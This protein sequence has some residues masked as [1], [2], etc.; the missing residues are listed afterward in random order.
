MHT[1][2]WW[3][4]GLLVLHIGAIRAQDCDNDNTLIDDVNLPDGTIT[5][6]CPGTVQTPCMLG[7]EYVIVNVVAGN[8]YTFSTCG[9]SWD[10]QLTLWSNTNTWLGMNDNYGPCGQ[11]SQ[12]SWVATYTGPVWVLL[13]ESYCG[14]FSSEPTPCGSVAV[15]CTPPL[16]ND[17]CANATPVGNGLTSFSTIG[18]TG[19][20]ISSC[21][22]NDSRDVWF[23]YEA[24]CLGTVTVSTCGMANFNTSISIWNAC[25]GAGTQQVC[26]DDGAGCGL[27][28][29]VTFAVFPG[30]SYWIRVSGVNASMGSGTLGIHCDGV[31]AEDAC[32]PGV[33]GGA[34]P[35][36]GLLQVYQD[37]SPSQLISDV[38]LGD[39][40]E[41]SNITY[42]GAPNAIGR[43][44]N[45]WRIGIDQ[46]IILTTGNA[47]AADGSPGAFASS[48]N[49]RP[50]NALLTGLAGRQTYDA[51]VFQ[52][53]FVP[54]TENVTFTYVFA[55]E[56]YPEWVCTSFNDVFGFFVSGPGYAPNTN[57]ATVP[58][59]FFPVAIN[60][61]NNNGTC[62]VNPPFSA[63]Y[64]TNTGAHNVYDGFTVPLTTCINTT[65]CE[66]YTITIAVADAGD[67]IYDS[68][69]FLEAES[70]TAGVDLEIG[71]SSVD[72]QASTVDNCSDQGSF[73][74]TLEMPMEEEV[75]LTYN[76]VQ[77]GS[78]TFSP[79]IPI[80]VTFPPGTTSLVLPVNAVIGSMGEEVSTVTVILD[81]SLNP[82]L[83]CS[84][85]SDTVTATLFFCDTDP[86]PVT[87]LDFQ[88]FSINGER[89]VLCTW[90]T[91]SEI[92]SAEF[93]VERSPD[94]RTWED[95]GGLPGA[96]TTVVPQRYELVDRSP[97]G[98]TS[99]YRVRQTDTDGRRDHSVVRP[100]HRS[101]PGGLHAY[102]NPGTGRFQ[103]V[104]HENGML[105][106][107]DLSGRAVPFVLD[108]GGKLD[109]LDAAP[110]SY[111]VEVYLDLG[112]EPQRIRLVV[113]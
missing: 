4:L 75:T 82:G 1:R 103:L 93:T 81:T 76:L 61:V 83:G 54:E 110:G 15:T 20:D 35:G 104:G 8:V 60:T 90:Q 64:V 109:L 68:A 87:W 95:I 52:F 48:G 38:F 92:N 100:V 27:T 63:Y 58:G 78:G 29:T 43:F 11:Q 88:A 32:F 45:G 59:T 77:E 80:T 40:L 44:T 23:V 105:M 2:H 33:A 97:L 111:V 47:A 107:H 39:C 36:S 30:T 98:G 85:T 70:F 66:T 18:A 3:L 21:A 101:S 113:K 7:G 41:A 94:A 69:V 9:N 51:A 91:A 26:N 50:G 6:A 84:C 16:T 17:L 67:G 65:P 37:L 96:G 89:E 71:A 102:P 112:L 10:T 28:S 86:L 53:T 74:F 79:A 12:L 34:L 55:S 22:T 108:A 73:V 56:E 25:P 13:D 24:T 49:G 72:A 31:A 14:W 19:T 5:P 42:T 106:V 46:G 62:V 57:I 99:Y